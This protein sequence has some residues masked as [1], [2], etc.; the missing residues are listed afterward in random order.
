M[1]SAN[2]LTGAAIASDGCIYLYDIAVPVRPS[3]LP[4]QPGFCM[5]GVGPFTGIASSDS[6]QI[7]AVVD[8]GGFIATSYD[9]GFTFVKHPEAGSHT[10]SGVASS[11]DGSIMV[12]VALDSTVSV[13]TNEGRTWLVQPDAPKQNWTHVATTGD[14]LTMVAT[15]LNGELYTSSDQGE[16]WSSLT[17]LPG[18]LAW[19]SV[20]LSTSGAMRIASVRVSPDGWKTENVGRSRDGCRV[21]SLLRL[22]VCTVWHSEMLLH[23]VQWFMY[24]TES[25]ISPSTMEPRGLVKH[26]FQLPEFGHPWQLLGTVPVR[27]RCSKAVLSIYIRTVL[28]NHDLEPGAAYGPPWMSHT[29]GTSFSLGQQVKGIG[30]RRQGG[31]GWEEPEPFV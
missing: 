14:G 28:G 5:D 4:P 21:L 11:S 1:L 17:S 2:G 15:A 6:G 23:P 30:R 3:T 8:Q 24:R 19:S 29:T 26:H 12:A 27:L 22:Q 31:H 16:H 18:N 7:V 25:C 9:L 10:W 13:S 20:D